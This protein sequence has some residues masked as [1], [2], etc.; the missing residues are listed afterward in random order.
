MFGLIDFLEEITDRQIQLPFVL[1]FRKVICFG[2]FHLKVG[3]LVAYGLKAPG[4]FRLRHEILNKINQRA[5]SNRLNHV[6]NWALEIN[7][8]LRERYSL[9][10]KV[11]NPA[12]PGS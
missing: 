10:Q 2:C 3:M 7:V 11:I 5:V 12:C 6:V 8:S 1:Y 9:I 4:S